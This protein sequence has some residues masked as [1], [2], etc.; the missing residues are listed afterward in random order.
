MSRRLC[1]G[2]AES[3]TPC[4]GL[5][6]DRIGDEGKADINWGALPPVDLRAVCFLREKGLCWGTAE[7]AAPCVGLDEDGVG[8][9]GKADIDWGALPPVDLRAVCFLRE[10]PLG[11]C[12]RGCWEE[13]S[14][15][16]RMKSSSES[17]GRSITSTLPVHHLSI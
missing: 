11:L 1:W 8:D 17:D 9:A 13:M 14:P 16:K 12:R 5:D 10:R 7:Y 15:Q 2:T 6:E 4:V 3:V